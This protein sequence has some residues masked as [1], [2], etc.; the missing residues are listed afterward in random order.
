MVILTCFVRDA[1]YLGRHKLRVW[2]ILSTYSAHAH[3]R[4]PSLT[5]APIA[6]GTDLS[7]KAACTPARVGF[8]K[9]FGASPP[10]NVC[11]WSFRT[12][13]PAQGPVLSLWRQSYGLCPVQSLQKTSR[14]WT[15]HCHLSVFLD[16][17]KAAIKS[18]EIF[19]P[20]CLLSFLVLLFLLLFLRLCVFVVVIIISFFSTLFF[21]EVGLNYIVPLNLVLTF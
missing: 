9:P 19:P 14:H 3:S 12:S 4:A 13:T 11:V 5:T 15:C 17:W 2:F 8:R 18:T 20:W 6:C 21:L 7:P 10:I 1:G 16:L